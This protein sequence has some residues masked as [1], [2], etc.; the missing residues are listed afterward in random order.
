M[1]TTNGSFRDE[2]NKRSELDGREREAILCLATRPREAPGEG[3][4]WIPYLEV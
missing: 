4:V 2:D 3:C 1:V